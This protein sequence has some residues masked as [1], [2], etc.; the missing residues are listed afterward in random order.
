MNGQPGSDGNL[1][2]IMNRLFNLGLRRGEVPAGNPGSFQ[3][4]AFIRKILKDKQSRRAGLKSHLANIPF[5]FLDT[6]T[7]GFR[8]DHGDQIF[9]VAAFKVVNGEITEKFQ[10]LI[11]PGIPIPESVSRLTGIY[12]KDV[13]EAPTLDEKMEELLQFFSKCYIIGY[14]ISHDLTFINHYLWRR[15][16]SSLKQPSLELAQLMENLVGD[17]AFPTLDSAVDHFG[18]SCSKR[19]TAEGDVS[20]MVEIWKHLLNICQ[21]C[22]IV[23]LEDLYSRI[24]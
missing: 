15:Y 21:Q 19:H 20:M 5:V 18:I 13:E 11:H 8:P 4:E 3:H 23:T 12:D 9:S 7:T 17:K 16:R 22:G 6:E 24:K 14:H 1:K 10:T 2:F